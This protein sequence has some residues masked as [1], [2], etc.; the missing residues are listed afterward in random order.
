M[1]IC[2]TY[3]ND[4]TLVLIFDQLH[5]DSMGLT[6]HTNVDTLGVHLVG[7]DHH[8]A[9]VLASIHLLHVAELQCAIVLKG[10]LSMVEWEQCRVLVPL[11]GIVRVAYHTAVNEGIPSC[12]RC[13]VFHWTDAGTA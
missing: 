3:S 13:D 2:T 6:S 11:Y 9:V 1:I 8:L 10:S 7:L 4:I 12:N 5:G